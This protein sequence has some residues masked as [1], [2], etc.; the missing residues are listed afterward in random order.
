MKIIQSLPSSSTNNLLTVVG[1]SHSNSH[2]HSH[3]HRHADD[4]VSVS[5]EHSTYAVVNAKTI[6]TATS[7]TTPSRR[8]RHRCVQIDTTRNEYYENTRVSEDDI[9]STWLSYEEIKQCK[10]HTVALAK[11]VYRADLKQAQAQPNTQTYSSVVLDAYYACCRASY[12]QDEDDDKEEEEERTTE[13]TTVLSP[14][15][16]K[17]LLQWMQI[18]LLRHGLERTA[19]RTIATDKRNRRAHIVRAVLDWQDDEEEETNCSGYHHHHAHN[20]ESDNAVRRLSASISR[21]SRLFARE[22]AAVVAESL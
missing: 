13:T 20:D 2:S 4:E 7:T 5:S 18:G 17:A 19:V 14:T 6:D 12:Q 8:R 10:G 11:E 22:M 3:S 15:E 16:H 21:P 9:S 1:V